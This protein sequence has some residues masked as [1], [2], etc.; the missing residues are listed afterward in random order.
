[1]RG[2]QDDGQVEAVAPDEQRRRRR[3]Q[4][5][6]EQRVTAGRADS[7]CQRRLQHLAGLAGIAHDQHLR[8][9]HAGVAGR[10]A[11]ERERELGGQEV[12]G[13]AANA[14]GPEQLARHTDGWDTK[15][16]AR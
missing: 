7:R 16:S 1:M 4:H 6:A 14:V 5:A 13:D 10:G 3:R 11:P 9:L 8:A 2:G 12:T 15:R